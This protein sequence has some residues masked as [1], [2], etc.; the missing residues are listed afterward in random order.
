MRTLLKVIVYVLVI[1]LFAGVI[2]VIYKFTNGFNEDFKTFYVEYKGDKIL[3]TQTVLELETGKTHTFGVKYTFD[4]DD[5]K[6]KDYTVKVVPHMTKDFDYTVNGERYLFSKIKDFTAAFEIEKKETSFDLVMPAVTSLKNVLS[7]YHGGAHIEI[8]QSAID[9][10]PNPFTLVISSYNNSVVYNIGLKTVDMQ[11]DGLKVQIDGTDVTN[12]RICFYGGGEYIIEV[13]AKVNEEWID[14][15]EAAHITT[16]LGGDLDGNYLTITTVVSA[17]DYAVL[18]VEYGGETIH[19]AYC[20][21]DEGEDG[22]E[23]L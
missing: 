14:V 5:A 23:S 17:Y 8:E 16:E 11:V 9:A 6:P 21:H 18:Y 15:S 3:S 20:T 2:G 7:A 13:Y 4:K 22:W 1:A 19:V 12:K 10:N